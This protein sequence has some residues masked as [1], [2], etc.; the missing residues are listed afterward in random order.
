M[1]LRLVKR[2]AVTRCNVRHIWKS[3]NREVPMV[4]SSLRTWFVIHFL[5]DVLFALPLFLA[6]RWTLSLLGWPAV[7]P[8]ATRLVAAA[9]FGI[10]IQSLLGRGEGAAAFRALLNLKIIWSAAATV[11]LVWSEA[12]GRSRAR[13]GVRCDLRGLQRALG[14]LPPAPAR[15]AGRGHGVMREVWSHRLAAGVGISGGTSKPPEGAGSCA[16]IPRAS[17]STF[18][19]STRSSSSPSRRTCLAGPPAS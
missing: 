4:P 19:R 6:P 16:T 14:A 8:L 1:A 7:D 12:G 2:R 11:G 13:V 15:A 18:P 5:A 3:S 10:G 9:L 17:R